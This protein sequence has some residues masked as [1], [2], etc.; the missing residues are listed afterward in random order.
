MLTCSF[1][2]FM[3]ARV[4]GGFVLCFAPVSGLLLVFCAGGMSQW[5]ASLLCRPQNIHES[6][7]LQRQ[8]LFVRVSQALVY[9]NTVPPTKKCFCFFST[10]STAVFLFFVQ[11]VLTLFH[12]GM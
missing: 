7:L 1:L 4:V 5:P 8:P 11:G 12:V 2:D 9:P 6:V 10:P 3:F